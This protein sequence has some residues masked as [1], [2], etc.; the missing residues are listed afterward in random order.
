MTK[1]RHPVSSAANRIL[2]DAQVALSCRLPHEASNVVLEFDDGCLTASGEVESYYHKQLV[3]EALRLVRG[4]RRVIND[5][6]VSERQVDSQLTNEFHCSVDTRC[7]E[8]DPYVCST[9]S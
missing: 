6:I 8:P 4:I 3:Q 5:T 9:P 2:A 1:E 7:N